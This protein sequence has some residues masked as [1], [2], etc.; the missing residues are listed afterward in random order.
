MASPKTRSKAEAEGRSTRSH[1]TRPTAH[2][3]IQELPNTRRKR[4]REPI[5]ITHDAI[6]SKRPRIDINS[7]ARPKAQLKSRSHI[8]I[9]APEKPRN[10]SEQQRDRQPTS[11][12]TTKNV[13]GT[14]NEA[15]TPNTE[16]ATRLST[17][18]AEKVVAGIKHELDRLQPAA[19]DT[20]A[21]DEKR[22][23]RSQEGTRFKS[24]LALYF[25]DYDVVIGNEPEEIRE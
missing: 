22:K 8:V 17:K 11:K 19:A 7:V 4:Q 1:Q 3:A 25:P 23:L 12:T 21:K 9:D 18:H 2:K 16:A 10:I 5:E 14:K 24:E 13:N 20:K 15:Q 6:L